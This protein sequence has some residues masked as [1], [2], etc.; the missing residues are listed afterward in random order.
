[1][2]VMDLVSITTR[3]CYLIALLL[4]LIHLLAHLLLVHF[5]PQGDCE[6]KWINFLLFQFNWLGKNIV[7][8]N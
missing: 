4:Y 1:M 3:F 8:T 2:F 7:N 5:I 6:G